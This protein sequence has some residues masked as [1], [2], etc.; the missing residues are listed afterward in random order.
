MILKSKIE[1]ILSFIKII[2][3]YARLLQKLNDK[4]FIITKAK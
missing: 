2:S 4:A 3:T 1:L